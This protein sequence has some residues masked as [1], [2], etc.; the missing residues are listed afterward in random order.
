MRRGIAGVLGILT[1]SISV[2]FAAAV[3]TAD[4]L[5]IEGLLNTGVDEFGNVLATGQLE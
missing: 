1:V 4:S 2:S 5:P 3:A